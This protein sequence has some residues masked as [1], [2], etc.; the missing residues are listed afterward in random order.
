MKYVKLCAVAMGL[1][2]VSGNANSS[3]CQTN[4]LFQ[5]LRN[6]IGKFDINFFNKIK[7]SLVP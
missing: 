7:A 4:A 6:F 2:G 5:V 3:I 1:G